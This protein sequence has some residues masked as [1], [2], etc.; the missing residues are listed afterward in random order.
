[1]SEINT[2]DPTSGRDP[3]WPVA[4]GSHSKY[5]PKV[6]RRVLPVGPACV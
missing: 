5:A 6:E 3:S 1:V 4:A 2:V